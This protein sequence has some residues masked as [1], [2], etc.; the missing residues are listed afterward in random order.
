MNETK[1][2]IISLD[3]GTTS[4]RALLIDENGTIVATRQKEIESYYPQSG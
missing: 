1:K 4:C 2:Y 3:A